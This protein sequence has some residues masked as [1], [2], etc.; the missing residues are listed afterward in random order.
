MKKR[1]LL[2]AVGL[3]MMTTAAFAGYNYYQQSQI[4]PAILENAEAMSTPVIPCTPVSGETC[5]F[6]CA[7]AD[8]DVGK[9]TISDHKYK[10]ITQ[11]DKLN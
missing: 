8:G 10:S 2:I 9:M 7:N 3:G 11:V 6:N 4:A 1:L 5:T